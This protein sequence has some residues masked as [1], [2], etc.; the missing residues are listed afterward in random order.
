MRDQ[1][2]RIGVVFR[3]EFL[4]HFRDRRSLGMALI[5]PLL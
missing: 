5:Y 1:I 2:R 4:D 3:K